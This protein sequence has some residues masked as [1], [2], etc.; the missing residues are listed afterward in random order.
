MILRSVFAVM[1]PSLLAAGAASAIDV[2]IVDPSPGEVVFGD[3]EIE[4]EV[5]SEAGI[6]Q[7]EVFVDGRFVGA[8]EEPPWRFRADVGE[9]NAEHRFEVVAEG[10]DGS[11]DSALLVS[12]RFEVDAEIDLELQQLYVTVTRG[13]GR[14]LDLGVG[15]F[16][17]VDQRQEQQLVTFEGGDVPLVALLLV[18]AS[19]SMRGDRLAAAVAGAE[20]FIAGMNALDQ[21]KLLMFS[22]RVRHSTPF[23]NFAEV[24][25]TGLAGVQAA[26][27]TALNDHLYLALQQLDQRQGR[28]VVVLLSDGID[29]ASVLRASEVLRA[30]RR[31]QAL[32]YWLRLGSLDARGGHSSAWRDARGHRREY[33]VLTRTVEQSGGRILTLGHVDET[34]AAFA[35]V[36]EELHEQYVLGYYPTVNRGDGRWHEVEVRVRGRGLRVRTREGY[37]DF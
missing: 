32:I 13:D 28:R 36:L 33:E 34:A 18:D 29:V 2:T 26:G 1:V 8:R 22:D 21:A 6:R 17:V 31:S 5:Y 24:L 20:A 7:V 10:L 11:R 37:F 9:A 30:A 23:T 4:A 3:V 14:V 19:N 16:A 27:N 35:R 25:E 15:D 12:P